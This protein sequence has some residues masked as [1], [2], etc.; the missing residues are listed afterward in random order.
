[1]LNLAPN[2]SISFWPSPTV[3]QPVLQARVRS[4][5]HRSAEQRE[6]RVLAEVV[7]RG[8]VAHL[9]GAVLHRIEDLQ[10]GDDFARGEHL[11]LELVVGRFADGLGH[12][13]GAAL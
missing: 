2:S 11:D 13:V 1:M 6:G 10:A 9:D 3:N 4:E 7:V 8:G 5:R 12:H